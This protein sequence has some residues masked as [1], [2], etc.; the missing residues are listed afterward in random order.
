MP[1]SLASEKEHPAK[2][3][4][5]IPLSNHKNNKHCVPSVLSALCK[6]SY[7]I[8]MTILCDGKVVYA[9]GKLTQ[10]AGT[11]SCPWAQ[12][13]WLQG[14]AP[15]PHGTFPCRWVCLRLVRRE[16][17]KTLYTSYPQESAL[18]NGRNGRNGRRTFTFSVYGFLYYLTVFIMKMH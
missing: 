8:L 4:H 14:P 12:A 7:L 10:L 11:G 13:G 15:A 3:Y 6:A 16:P 9:K 1:G 2:Q 5:N 17:R 18:G